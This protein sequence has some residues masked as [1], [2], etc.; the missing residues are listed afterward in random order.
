[1][2]WPRTIGGR[3]TLWY[4]AAFSSALLV[5]GV[6]MWLAVQQSLYHAIDEGLL[7]RIE[8]IQVFIED[9]KDSL[10]QEEVR[11]E[12]R[13]HGELFQVIDQNGV[14]IHRAESFEGAPTP[15]LAGLDAGPRFENVA[16]NGAPL[17]FRSQSI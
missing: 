2:R 3:L 11:E 1:M 4:T 6:V 17:R 16:V 9:H 7:H 14:S 12:F 13:A 8:G 5:L 10:D 15:P